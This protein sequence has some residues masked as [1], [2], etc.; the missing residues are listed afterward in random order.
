MP[1]LRNG[2]GIFENF[3][4]KSNLGLHAFSVKE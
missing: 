2:S 3:F 4:I 1:H